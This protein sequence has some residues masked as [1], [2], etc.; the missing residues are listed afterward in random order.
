MQ[1]LISII[2]RQKGEGFSLVVKDRP[3]QDFYNC[4][5]I[6]DR[7]DKKFGTLFQLNLYSSPILLLGEINRTPNNNGNEEKKETSTS[8]LGIPVSVEWQ[9]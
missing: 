8:G 3:V 7:T 5:S 6:F 1:N 2:Q 4:Q 9:T